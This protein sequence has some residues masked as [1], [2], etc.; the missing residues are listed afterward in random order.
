MKGTVQSE[1]VEVPKIIT[2]H[3]SGEEYKLLE[4]MSAYYWSIPNLMVNEAHLQPY[5]QIMHLLL[6]TIDTLTRR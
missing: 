5:M 2:L 3:V 1:V 4:Q 6:Y